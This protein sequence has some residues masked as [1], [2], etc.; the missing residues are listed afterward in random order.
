MSDVSLRYSQLHWGRQAPLN[1]R[2]E[3]LTVEGL[4]IFAVAIGQQEV[5]K[6]AFR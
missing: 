2:I 5:M 3:N 4:L 1:L 6:L